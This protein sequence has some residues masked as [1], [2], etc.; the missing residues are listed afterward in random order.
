MGYRYEKY[1]KNNMCVVLPREI[2]GEPLTIVGA[3]AFL[4]CRRVEKLELPD[5]LERV[6]DWAFAHMKG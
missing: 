1:D 6:E 4:S 2:G 5:T 3:K